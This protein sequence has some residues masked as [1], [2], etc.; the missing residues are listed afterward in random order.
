[1]IFLTLYRLIYGKFR[2]DHVLNLGMMDRE[3]L[4]WNRAN[5]ETVASI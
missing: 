1:M 2:N 5:P 3:R 4:H